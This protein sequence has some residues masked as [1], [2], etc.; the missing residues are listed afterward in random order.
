MW[1]L[2]PT[3]LPG[4]RRRGSGVGCKSTFSYF[5]HRRLWGKKRHLTPTGKSVSVSFRVRVV[6]ACERAR[7]SCVGAWGLC[8][9]TLEAR[10]AT[11]ATAA[12]AA[13]WVAPAFVAICVGFKQNLAYFLLFAWVLRARASICCYMR[14]F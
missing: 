11:L 9:S 13:G 12:P 5:C 7:R 4:G 3:P 2:H 14:G 1:T 10:T 8:F 6:R